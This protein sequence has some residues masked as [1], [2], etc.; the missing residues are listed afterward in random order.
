VR[1]EEGVSDRGGSNVADQDPTRNPDFLHYTVERDLAYPCASLFEIAE[2]VERYPEFLPGWKAV[3]TKPDTEADYATDQM[4]AFG[5]VRERFTSK[6]YL[7]RPHR[8]RV[9]SQSRTFRHF[10]VN[11]RFGGLDDAKCRVHLDAHMGFKSRY[12]KGIV[13]KM[14]GKR[15]D[16]ILSAF[17]GRAAVMLGRPGVDRG[18]E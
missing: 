16:E 12:V 5:P 14:L 4:L 9:V 11:W 3:R 6:T 2:D 1:N 10:E 7:D 8:I 17:E 15:L 13:G 18:D